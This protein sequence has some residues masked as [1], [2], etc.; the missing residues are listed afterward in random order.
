MFKYKLGA[1]L[2]LEPLSA[3]VARKMQQLNKTRT[4]TKINT[5]RSSLGS[6]NVHLDAL[7]ASR[8]QFLNGGIDINS[9]DP[10]DW[11]TLGLDQQDPN[12]ILTMLDQLQQFADAS[13]ADR[14]RLAP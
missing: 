1:G 4:I 9:L 2:K 12:Q 13:F 14:V 11:E 3:K 7:L 5:L 10:T 8:S 6:F